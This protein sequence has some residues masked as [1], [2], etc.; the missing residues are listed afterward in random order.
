MNLISKN[1]H[2]PVLLEPTLNFDLK[3]MQEIYDNYT[4]V[5]HASL[6]IHAGHPF[7][8]QEFIKHIIKEQSAIKEVFDQFE[9]SEYI[10]LYDTDYQIHATLIELA[11]QHDFRNSRQ[12]LTEKELF[13]NKNNKQIDINYAITWIQKTDPFEIE[14]AP[15]VLPEQHQGQTIK[16]TDSGQIVMQGRP[17]DK[18]LI[19]KCRSEFEDNANIVHRYGRENDVFYFVIGFLKP[20]DSLLNKKF[21]LAL[22]NCLN[23]RRPNIKVSLRVDE[24]TIG[25]FKNF[26]SNKDS[27]VYES[28]KFKLGEKLDINLD[29]QE[30]ILKI[31]RE[32]NSQKDKENERPLLF[33]NQILKYKEN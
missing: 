14:L 26:S 33:N 21:R 7:T 32:N 27:C 1:D 24:V 20:H 10:L 16:I 15:D 28:K 31:I 6:S 13:F 17:K 18:G 30:I 11:L 5:P 12:F 9:L 25:M 29:L 2:N 23:D 3:K 4:T 19:S 22:E 8:D